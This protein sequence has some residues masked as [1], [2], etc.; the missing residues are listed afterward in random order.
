MAGP[1]TL[2]RTQRA[3]KT[4]QGPAVRRCEADGIARKATAGISADVDAV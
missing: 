2:K 1:R 4:L 3:V